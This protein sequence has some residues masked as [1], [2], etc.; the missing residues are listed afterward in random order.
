MKRNK[1]IQKIEHNGLKRERE[2]RIQKMGM[3]IQDFEQNV[4][5]RDTR[6][7][8]IFLITQEK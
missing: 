3:R 8:E 5:K 4:Q 7:R 2:K 6:T 1:R